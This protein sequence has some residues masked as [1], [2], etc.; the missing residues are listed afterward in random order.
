[1]GRTAMHTD[2]GSHRCTLAAPGA[3][4][5]PAEP[6]SRGS[7]GDGDGALGSKLRGE[8][9]NR[10]EQPT[11]LE[12]D[13]S[14]LFLSPLAQAPNNT[15]SRSSDHQPPRKREA[16]FQ[17]TGSMALS[18]SGLG[19]TTADFVTKMERLMQEELA[20]L[21]RHLSEGMRSEEMLEAALNGPKAD[22]NP[23]R[24]ARGGANLRREVLNSEIAEFKQWIPT[25]ALSLT[26]TR[27]ARG[28][29]EAPRRPSP[30]R[31][32]PEWASPPRE[33][34]PSPSEEVLA[35]HGY[36]DMTQREDV[37]AADTG[38]KVA[39]QTPGLEAMVFERVWQ[40]VA[41][42]VFAQALLDIANRTGVTGEHRDARIL[43]DNRPHSSR[44]SSSL[45][46]AASGRQGGDESKRRQ[47]RRGSAPHRRDDVNV[48][49][50]AGLPFDAVTAGED[51]KRVFRR[52]TTCE[53]GR[54]PS[55][56]FMAVVTP[57]A[58]SDLPE[59]IQGKHKGRYRRKPRMVLSSLA[60]AVDPGSQATLSGTEMD[61]DT[62]VFEDVQEEGISVAA[63]PKRRP[64]SRQTT[65]RSHR[66][67]PRTPSSKA[68]VGHP[69][70]SQQPEIFVHEFDEDS[71]CEVRP[72]VGTTSALDSPSTKVNE[73]ASVFVG[74]AAS[75]SSL[76]RRHKVSLSPQCAGTAAAPT[77]G[78]TVAHPHLATRNID[79]SST[80]H[81]QKRP[82]QRGGTEAL[83]TPSAHGNSSHRSPLRKAGLRRASKEKATS[84]SERASGCGSDNA[85]SSRSPLYSSSV[86][87]R[88][89][90]YGASP[91]LA[92][93]HQSSRAPPAR[94]SGAV[95]ASSSSPFTNA[96]QRRP[97]KANQGARLGT[98]V[99]PVLHPQ[100]A[101]R[102]P[103]PQAQGV[104]RA[105]E[106]AAVY[107]AT[108]RRPG[109]KKR[110]NSPLPL[111][112][113][114]G[115]VAP[116]PRDAAAAA[117]AALA[118]SG[119][120]C[121]LAS[122]TALKSGVSKPSSSRQKSQEQSG[123]DGLEAQL[124]SSISA[125]SKEMEAMRSLANPKKQRPTTASL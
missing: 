116:Q 60:S 4:S 22:W 88:F 78:S 39:E 53:D 46:K 24:G 119:T 1:M 13:V 115:Q 23:Y 86:P 36:L 103:S 15:S 104:R 35:Q 83:S 82:Q 77:A 95:L 59:R 12:E 45:G 40:E 37:R 34:L 111:P 98:S 102:K 33:A 25:D 109:V 110:F 2:S 91:T 89:A 8:G 54:P 105:N 49:T 96:K 68:G 6:F 80:P 19:S 65:G 75:S 61:D 100:P 74:G 51:G 43:E 122:P 106:P 52:P 32:S 38:E 48:A 73:D 47:P 30:E 58:L 120:R 11:P 10:A 16:S 72:G 7:N 124:S 94:G 9:G 70:P 81:P 85:N 76:S 17:S 63:S 41:V 107:F 29:A 55:H 97:A 56:P 27:I 114:P 118:F 69:N 87:Q 123:D 64:S 101:E 20:G 42:P 92:G 14:S 21:W 3:A 44:T 66:E 67:S 108:D 71:D 57:L 99:S 5:D 31:A 28:P 117:D 121:G 84:N 50:V 18:L 125:K 26:G 93:T 112:R 90:P 113:A 79:E 62:I